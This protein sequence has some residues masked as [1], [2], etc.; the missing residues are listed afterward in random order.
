MQSCSSLLRIKFESC[1]LNVFKTQ[2][3]S[4]LYTNEYICAA[5]QVLPVKATSTGSIDLYANDYDCTTVVYPS[6]SQTICDQGEST[7]V[8]GLFLCV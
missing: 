3:Y 1:I 7:V 8:G 4:H 5:Q 6:W 2:R